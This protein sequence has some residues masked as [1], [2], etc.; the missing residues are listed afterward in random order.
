MGGRRIWRVLLID[1]DAAFLQQMQ[2]AF[3]KAGYLVETAPNGARALERYEAEPADLVV[4]D[5]FMPERDGLE[6]IMA[7][8]RVTPTPQI[9]AID[10]EPPLGGQDWLEV[11]RRMGAAATLRKPFELDDLLDTAAWLL[12]TDPDEPTA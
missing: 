10:G 6:T 7:L 5:I 4:T 9:V 2:T 11:A 3:R 1:D 8:A 12:E